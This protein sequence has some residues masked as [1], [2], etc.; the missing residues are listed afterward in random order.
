MSL[1]SSNLV[2]FVR[3]FE[4]PKKDFLERVS[5]LLLTPVHF[6][7]GYQIIC[8]D[9]DHRLSAASRKVEGVFFWFLAILAALPISFPLI[10]AG[11]RLRR[12]SSS[13]KEIYAP[14]A[15]GCSSVMTIKKKIL[16]EFVL[17]YIRIKPII[18]K[19]LGLPIHRR[20]DVI[21]SRNAE[22][23]LGSLPLK[24]NIDFLVSKYRPD[25]VLSILEPFEN[26]CENIRFGWFE[27]PATP[28]DW[29][30]RGIAHK[31]VVSEDL[32][33]VEPNKLEEGVEFLKS[34][35]DS[36]RRVLVH[37][38]AGMGRS[39]LIVI[40]FLMKHR[41][42]SFEEVYRYVKFYR[43]QVHL[44][45]NQLDRNGKSWQINGRKELL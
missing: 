28:D 15:A 10:Y 29:A 45:K 33:K 37:C 13:H 31:Q 39:A 32:Q 17:L 36:G 12:L 3:E 11:M 16:F 41:K 7:F 21:P 2:R 40:A 25:S 44:F 14:L 24:N 20:W 6:A 27:H 8:I 9:K 22:I 38:K 34:E 18:Q 5:G 1:Y 26:D 42:K 23:I 30:Q 19:M 4:S 35:I 43:P